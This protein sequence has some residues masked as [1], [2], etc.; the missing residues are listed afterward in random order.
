MVGGVVQDQYAASGWELIDEEML[1]KGDK[2]LLFFF[3]LMV[4]VTVS[5]AQL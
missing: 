2:G 3:S 1:E 4:H 5:S